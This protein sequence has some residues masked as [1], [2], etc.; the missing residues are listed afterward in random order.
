MSGI[1]NLAARV[2]STPSSG[3]A[4]KETMF[5]PRI[6]LGTPASRACNLPLDYRG[7]FV[8]VPRSWKWCENHSRGEQNPP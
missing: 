7:R 3:K 2:M 8:K 4:P 5:R 1:Q 6:E